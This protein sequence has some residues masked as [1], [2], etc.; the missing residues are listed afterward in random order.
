MRK[1]LVD[2]FISSIL[3]SIE[4][5][6]DKIY[7]YGPLEDLK[8]WLDYVNN[9]IDHL[10]DI[11]PDFDIIHE[12]VSEDIDRLSRINKMISEAEYELNEMRK[13]K[14]VILDKMKNHL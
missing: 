3:T 10:Q 14:E 5:G 13:I 8:W 2:D 1:K 9:R 6:S 7:L 12:S 11:L 4:D